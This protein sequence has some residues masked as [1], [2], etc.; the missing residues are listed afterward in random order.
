MIYIIFLEPQISG[1]VG[2]I[3]RSMKNFDLDKLII[4]NPRCNPKDQ[5]A[6][7]RAKHA[8]NILKSAQIYDSILDM[9]ENMNIDYLV[10]TTGALGRDYNIPRVPITPEQFA[11]KVIKLNCNSKLNNSNKNIKNNNNNNKSIKNNKDQINIALIIGRE[12]AGLTNEEILECDFTVTIPASIEYPIL[13][14]SH[15]AS[16]IFYELFKNSKS[17]SQ[18]SHIKLA[19]DKDKQILLEEVDKKLRETKFATESK[20]ETQ[21]KLWKRLVGKSFLSKREAQALIGFLKKL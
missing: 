9:R 3:C 20:R 12:N 2:A 15:A 10:G 21:R 16:I 4:I 18:S 19:D 1:N 13:N 8:N 5:D 17:K 11:K 6:K 7:N 14:A